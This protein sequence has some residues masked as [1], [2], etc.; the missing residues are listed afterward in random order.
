MRFAAILLAGLALT[1]CAT[2][3]EPVPETGAFSLKYVEVDGDYFIRVDKIG[4]SQAVTLADSHHPDRSDWRRAD[5]QRFADKLFPEDE[6]D[7]DTLRELRGSNL[8]PA[9][10]ASPKPTA[11]PPCETSVDPD[12][13]KVQKRVIRLAKKGTGA[14]TMSTTCSLHEGLSPGEYEGIH[15]RPNPYNF[16]TRYETVIDLDRDG[17]PE[18]RNVRIRNVPKSEI[19]AFVKFETVLPRE[20]KRELIASV[21]R[22]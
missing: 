20:L 22:L 13:A 10:L 7:F 4:V 17:R 5:W 12:Y 18:Q 3:L 11:I 15:Q 1:A 16:P 6:V 14:V 9:G 19:V 8:I 21:N 2:R